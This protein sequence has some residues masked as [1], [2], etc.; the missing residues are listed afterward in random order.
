MKILLSVNNLGLGG[1]STYVAHLAN[2]LSNEHSITIF[3]LYPYSSDYNALT[4]LKSNIEID[5]V[6]NYK[7]VDRFFWKVHGLFISFGTKLL[8]WNFWRK[9]LLKRLV[10]LKEID[11]IISFDKFSDA[12]ITQT[13]Y[14]KKPIILSLHGSYDI[15]PFFSIS[16]EE[17]VNYETIFRHCDAIV[18]KSDCNIEIL[19][20]YSNLDNIKIIKKVLHGFTAE[21]PTLSR[22]ILIEKFNIKI[23]SFIF[24]MIARGVKEKGWEEA[25]EAFTILCKTIN[26]IDF[27]VIGSSDYL[28]TLKEKYKHFLNIHFIGFVEKSID[29]V[30]L[31]D[32]GLLPTYAKTEN[33]TFSVVEYMFCQK[34]SIVT[35]H[36]ELAT[37]IEAGDKKMAGLL[38]ELNNGKPSVIDIVEAMK[39]YY[40][41]PELYKEHKA[42]TKI[43]MEKFDPKKSS[44]NYQSIIN[45]II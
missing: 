2:S 24:G 1:V 21:V 44:M 30:N 31:F 13:F 36:G 7:I 33:F 4:F 8:I 42:L 39:T 9:N 20:H 10:Y 25:L 12:I 18:Y 41:N 32:V 23:D 6:L 43:A 3:D 19:K 35:N 38:L 14:G 27:I 11:V 45:R 22:E 28:D 15:S 26:N 16:S 5:S 17:I 37:T 34:P 29:W 40:K